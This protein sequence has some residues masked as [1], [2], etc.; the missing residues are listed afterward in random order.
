MLG[1]QPEQAL[2]KGSQPLSGKDPSGYEPGALTVCGIYF[3]FVVLD[4]LRVRDRDGLLW[5]SRR[6]H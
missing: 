1:S 5:K 3:C 6:E 4:L 2:L